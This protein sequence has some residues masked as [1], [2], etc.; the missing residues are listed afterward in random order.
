MSDVLP[1]LLVAGPPFVAWVLY[2]IRRLC[3]FDLEVRTNR[4][5][6]RRLYE[7]ERD[8]TDWDR[9]EVR[10]VEDDFL[11][12]VLEAHREMTGQ[13]LLRGQALEEYRARRV[14]EIREARA[15]RERAS[16]NAVLVASMWPSRTARSRGARWISY[17]DQ[18]LGGRLKPRRSSVR[19]DIPAWV[20][21]LLDPEEAQRCAG[22]WGAHLH[23]Q[24]EDGE[25]REA[26]V[27]RRRFVRHAL[28]LAITRRA[29][30]ATS[31]S[32]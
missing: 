8:R 24:I 18:V 5:Q 28:V 25:V 32:R 31:R 13:E 15:E 2:V 29:R 21:A 27:D 10:I 30:R 9:E 14:R 3:A 7:H 16:R 26:R 12:E 11:D 4:E 6:Q 22:E 19:A 1:E 23:Q 20:L 17:L